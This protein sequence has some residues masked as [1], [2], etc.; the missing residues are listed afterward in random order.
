MDN[1]SIQVSNMGS[2]DIT[3]FDLSF[4]HTNSGAD[5]C[6]IVI[7]E[8]IQIE[9]LIEAG[10]IKN[11]AIPFDSIVQWSGQD[12]EVCFYISDIHP[13]LDHNLDNNSLC[14]PIDILSSSLDI[15]ADVLSSLVT[16]NPTTSSFMISA[17]EIFDGGKLFIT[18]IS[19][20]IIYSDTFF[21]DNKYQ[22]A[23]YSSGIYFYALWSADANHFST[24]KIILSP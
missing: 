7:S 20:Q 17:S 18:D 21:S 16:P 11:I 2:A 9:T 24:G 1:I 14:I 4:I 10:M 15:N 12:A 3:A 5:G 8:H 23:P 19:G 13:R 22:L 6:P